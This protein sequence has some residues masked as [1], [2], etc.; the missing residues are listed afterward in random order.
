MNGAGEGNRTLVIV[1]KEDSRGKTLNLFQNC[2]KAPRL[3]PTD[4]PTPAS[5]ALR[6]HSIHFEGSQFH[7]SIRSQ[8]RWMAVSPVWRCLRRPP[9]GITTSGAIVSRL[10]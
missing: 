6:H 8:P 7:P 2:D 4:S 1:A 10:A 3:L 5:S 9:T